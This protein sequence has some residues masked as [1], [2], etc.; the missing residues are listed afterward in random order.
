[1]TKLVLGTL[2]VRPPRAVGAA[3]LGGS[4]LTG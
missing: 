4:E 2:E 3:G 1:M